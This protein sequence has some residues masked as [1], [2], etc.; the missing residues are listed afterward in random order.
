MATVAPAL[1]LLPER[2]FHADVDAPGRTL[3]GQAA[4]RGDWDEWEDLLPVVDPLPGRGWAG[5][6]AGRRP[7][8][9]ADD[10]GVEFEDDAEPKAPQAPS[11]AAAPTR[12]ARDAGL[13][14]E[15]EQQLNPHER[16]A[17][18]ETPLHVAARHG[19]LDIVRSLVRD[20]QVC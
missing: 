20:H 9:I 11:V 12:E 10:A 2:P 5:R 4:A 16:D 3:L 17:Y 6:A 1:L 18:G 19:H 7:A 8:A 15:E 14:E 13:E